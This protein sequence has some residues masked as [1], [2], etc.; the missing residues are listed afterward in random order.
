MRKRFTL[1][2]EKIK[3][4][5]ALAVVCLL[6][7]GQ[8]A[9]GILVV[10][11][12]DMIPLNQVP[13]PQPPNLAQFVKNTNAAVRLGKA[14]FWDMQAGSD[15]I[16]ACATCHFHAGADSRLK[17]QINPGANAGDATFGDVTW[18]LAGDPGVLG[19]PQFG[20]NYLLEP[21]DFPLHQR[22]DPELTSSPVIFDTD[23]VIASQGVR[24][25]QFSGVLPGSAIDLTTPL[26]DPVFNLGLGHNLR[27]VTG[28][29]VP[30]VINA[31]FNF[32]NF[33]DGRAHFLFNGE[34]PFG[35]LDQGAGIWRE[36]DGQLVK[37]P[38]AIQ[39]AS[40]ASQ[41]VGPP[42]DEVEMSARGRT[43]PFLGRKL[44]SL[45]PLGKQL[46]HPG[47]SV[48]GPLSLATKLPDGTVT[49]VKGLNTSYTQMIQD[50]FVDTLWNSAE[51]TP[52]GFTQMEA[53][54]S[55]FWGL[56]IQ[57]YEAT[58]VSDQTRF[59]QFVGGDTTAMNDT[60]KLGFQVFL[61]VGA[62][63][64]CHVG[65]EFTS[66]SV[67]SI[68]FVN[69][70]SNRAIELM[71]T[72]DG[73]QVIYDQGFINTGVTPTEDDLGRGGTAPFTNPL[74]GQ[75]FPLS[76][77]HLAE[78][79]A[80]GQLPFPTLALPVV[81]PGPVP[82]PVPPD[83]PVSA[84]GLFKVPGLRNVELTA[85]YMHNGSMSTL[86]Q[87]V[88]FYIR[89]GNF[90]THNLAD[91]DPVILEGILQMVNDTA[92]QTALIAFLKTL[93]DQRVVRE[94]APFDHPELFI[95]E[96][97]PE[98]LTRI[99]ARDANG[100][101]SSPNSFPPSITSPPVTAATVGQLYSYGVHAHDANEDPLTF[102]L[103]LAPAGMT[104]NA[105][106]GM[107]TW[108][109][110]LEQVGIRNVT[111]RV[112]DPGGLFDSQTFGIAVNGPP[113]FT[114][115]PI[116]AAVVEQLYTYDVDANDASSFALVQAPLGMFID[117]STGVI[118]W[119]PTLAQDGPQSV[120]VRASD[121]L[122]LF[123]DQNFTILVNRSPVIISN[124]VTTA[125]AG[126]PYTTVVTA[127]DVDTFTYSLAL[128]PAGMTIDPSTGVI[129]WNPS[130]EQLGPST[131][132]VL[133]TDVHGLRASQSFT[134]MVTDRV[135]VG[136][137]TFR[138]RDK[139]WRITGRCLPAN[140]E[141]RT[142]TITLG[143]ELT[144]KII[145]AATVG[146]NGAWN[147]TQA[148]SPLSPPKNAKKKVISVRSS[149]GGELLKVRIRILQ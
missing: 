135:T 81:V 16:Q 48:L 119:T 35:P 138:P 63:A 111:I 51:S 121:P 5:L 28:R 102:S 142:V 122:G 9:W 117:S 7:P 83:F 18:V 114:S 77:S 31:V 36:V 64:A 43:F 90:P 46:V 2:T 95:P 85:P 22:V 146:T 78:L 110:T 6:L 17:N 58:L 56:A 115:T 26:D 79:E 67:R 32:S 20:P 11:P 25:S 112:T 145:G 127:S 72:A 57:L 143:P 34:N 109:P 94:S 80:L 44:L 74:T 14:F 144:G 55:L 133:V 93:T 118:R 69:N 104:I 39:F 52:A 105:S 86:N 50:A 73:N 60:E 21:T 62:C 137:A 24:L 91:L 132:T 107:I 128:A 42:L 41:A 54:F 49:D 82:G 148:N 30:S 101:T 37:Q 149:G 84:N 1:K 139:R 103:V 71:F 23:D 68:A 38:V 53:N 108:T 45:T 147:F 88:D 92:R 125:V 19:F 106:S 61:G 124:P 75:R 70:L 100:V 40:L 87:V 99:L 15:G 33:W 140:G 97:E 123:A 29:H 130:V 89:S 66:H 8:I 59:D 47:D 131:V 134:V 113:S 12:A 136:K 10:P 126:K 141:P 116:T 129:T 3:R 65:T 4:L 76:F 96:G 13:I 27:R 98:V 120:I